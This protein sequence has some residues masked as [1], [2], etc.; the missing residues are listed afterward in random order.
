MVGRT[1]SQGRLNDD[2]FYGGVVEIG[3]GRRKPRA[4]CQM[5]EARPTVYYYA[6]R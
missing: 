3:E 1:P 6:E 2:E 5:P 4:K